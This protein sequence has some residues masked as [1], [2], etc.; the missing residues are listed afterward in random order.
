MPTPFM[1]LRAAH[2]FLEHPATPPRLRE[3]LSQHLGPFLLGNVAPDAR[4]SGGLA[5][6]NTHFF[7]YTPPKVDPP[8]K[9]NLFQA[10]PDL[11]QA[12]GA[13]RAFIAGYLAHLAMDVVWAEKMLFEHLY[14]QNWPG[15][16]VGYIMLHVLL[17]H[18]DAGDYQQWPAH[19]APA[20][21]SAEPQDWLPFL[22][23]ADLRSWRDIIAGQI[24]P[25]CHSQTLKILGARVRIGE[26]GLREILESPE[27][28]A[29]ELWAYIPDEV[30][31]RVGQLMAESMAADVLE[32]MGGL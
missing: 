32:Y 31:G 24:C 29:R 12:T 18:L 14:R 19:F 7:E 30:L 4:V 16:G 6:S 17:C 10:H 20:L 21:A 13:R 23:D 15:E 1:H 9:V 25:D 27:R 8:A 26:G 5:R 28:L 2:L 22:G 3:E 11:H